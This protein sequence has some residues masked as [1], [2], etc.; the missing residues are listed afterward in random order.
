MFSHQNVSSE[1]MAVVC[2]G[3]AFHTRAAATAT[4]NMSSPS[5]TSSTVVSTEHELADGTTV[6]AALR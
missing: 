4:A 2:S 5:S 6:P 1:Q 3:K